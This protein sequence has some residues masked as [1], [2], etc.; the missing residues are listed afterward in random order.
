MYKFY[1]VAYDN[2]KKVAKSKTIFFIT[3]NTCG[4]YGNTTNIKVSP[5][6]KT[7]TVGQTLKLNVTTKTYKNKQHLGG[8]SVKAFKYSSECPQIASVN[9]KGIVKALAPGKTCIHV[10]DK[11]GKHCTFVITVKS[12]F[13]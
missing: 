2:N 12:L 8:K 10:Q 9:S 7:L 1:V 3:A 5:S 4:K 11:N 13:S 6:K